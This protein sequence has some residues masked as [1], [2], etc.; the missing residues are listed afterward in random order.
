MFWKGKSLLIFI[1]LLTFVLSS[2]K[3]KTPPAADKGPTVTVNYPIQRKATDHLELVGNIQATNT[4]QLVARVPGYLEKVLFQDGQ[5][6]KK[7]QLLFVIQQDT[8][9]AKLKEAQGQVE[10][11][12]SL[13]KYATAQYLRY[14]ELL[15]QKAAAQSDVDNWQYQRDAAEANLKVAE[16]NR[17]LAKLDLDYTQ[18]SAPFEGRIDRRLQDPGN[19]VGPGQNTLLAQLTQIDPLDVY[20]TIS[21][22]DLTRLTNTKKNFSELAKISQSAQLPNLAQPNSPKWEIYVGLVGE[23]GYPHKGYLDFTASTISTTTGTLLLRGVIPNPSGVI[24]PGTYAR[25]SIPLE[26]KDVLLLPEEAT[27]NDQMGSYVLVVDENN[28]VRRQAI[29]TGFSVGNLIVIAEGLKGSERVITNG[30]LKANPGRK[31]NPQMGN[32]ESQVE[33]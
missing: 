28:I 22:T 6:V 15:S 26:E 30:I 10:M 23:N 33:K 1:L 16:A 18:V 20:F 2:C 13:L 11:Q 8:Y 19:L 24:L 5:I 31:V 4:V 25:I 14:K 3:V 9:Q 17:D 29:K 27:N 32:L 21:D 7:D 12:E